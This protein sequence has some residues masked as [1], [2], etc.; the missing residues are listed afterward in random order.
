MQSSSLPACSPPAFHLLAF[1]PS[2]T[3]AHQPTSHLAFQ[4]I[5][6]LL[7]DGD[8]LANHVVASHLPPRPH[9]AQARS[10][11]GAAACG[12]PAGA[13]PTR[14]WPSFAGGCRRC[15]EWAGSTA[16]HTLSCT[17]RTTLHRRR[18]AILPL[19]SCRPMGS[20]PLHSNEPYHS[21]SS[22]ALLPSSCVLL[23]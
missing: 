10:L 15:C 6:P 22:H 11:W 20:P 8:A 12:R 9:G 18:S 14:P 3:P 23:V 2:S 17:C 1:Q 21:R 4:P 16:A 13:A 5:S 7:G 19:M